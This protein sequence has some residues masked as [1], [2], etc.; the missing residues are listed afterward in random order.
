MAVGPRARREVGAEV[1]DAGGDVVVGQFELVSEKDGLVYYY[2][3]VRPDGAYVNLY[4]I[5]C[6]SIFE[7]DLTDRI[8]KAMIVTNGDSKE[9]KVRS[10]VEMNLL[11]QVT[12]ENLRPGTRLRLVSTSP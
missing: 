9:C 4:S 10:A 12:L 6:G 7:A 1:L 11:A 2:F 8:P 3:A 5:N